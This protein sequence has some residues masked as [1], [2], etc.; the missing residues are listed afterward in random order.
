MLPVGT[1]VTTNIINGRSNKLIPMLNSLE[2]E[3]VRYAEPHDPGT[4]YLVA[5]DVSDTDQIRHSLDDGSPYKQRGWRGL[6]LGHIRPTEFPGDKRFYLLC[7]ASEVTAATT[8]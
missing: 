4:D 6:L 3:I 5:W 1:R 8:D 7:K 2:G